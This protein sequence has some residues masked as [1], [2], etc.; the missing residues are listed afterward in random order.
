MY[1]NPSILKFHKLPKPLPVL[2]DEGER[3][4][5]YFESFF[6]KEKFRDAGPGAGWALWQWRVRTS[7]LQVSEEVRR[8]FFVL[9]A[10]YALVAITNHDLYK[11]YHYGY[12]APVE[13]PCWV[14][15]IYTQ[16]AWVEAG[17]V[18]DDLPWFEFRVGFL[19]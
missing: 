3:E 11:S 6:N 4:T 9:A 12:V 2:L 16:P 8:A 15:S 5:A 7:T 10:R 1:H 14:T 17:V 13:N 19:Y 18:K